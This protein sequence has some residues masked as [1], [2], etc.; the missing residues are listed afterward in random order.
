MNSSNAFH[1]LVIST[2]ANCFE[3]SSP[4]RVNG[5]FTIESGA[6]INDN[7]QE[8]DCKSSVTNNGTHTSLSNSSTNTLVFS[9]TATQQISGTGTFGN[10]V[11]NNVTNVNFLGTFTINRRLTLTVG[12]VDLGDRNLKIGVD[13]EITGTFGLSE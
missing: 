3:T 11:I 2:G 5:T 10:V 7:S 9:G 13:G 6:T 4:I 1:N 8:I 12:L